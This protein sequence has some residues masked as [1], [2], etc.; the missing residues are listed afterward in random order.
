VEVGGQ[1]VKDLSLAAACNLG[2]NAQQLTNSAPEYKVFH[3]EQGLMVDAGFSVSRLAAEPYL[4]KVYYGNSCSSSCFSSLRET[5]SLQ[6]PML[7]LPYPDARR[8]T[9]GIPTPAPLF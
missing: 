6:W 1:V 8:C 3:F 4:N 9:A 7:L 2:A 5:G